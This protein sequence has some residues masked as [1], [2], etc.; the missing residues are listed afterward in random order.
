[1]VAISSPLAYS[2]TPG[3]LVNLTVTA[4]VL[5]IPAGGSV[6][7]SLDGGSEIPVAGSGNLYSL[8]FPGVANGNHDV[9]AIVRTD[10]GTEVASD[11]NS[12]VGTGGD[13][14]VTVGDSITNGV[15]DFNPANNDSADGRIVAIQSYQA[16]LSD[17]LTTTT[18]RP[19]IVFNEGIGGDKPADLQARIDSILERH[20]GANK[21]LLMIGTNGSQN[22][23]TRSG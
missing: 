18:G 16:R 14:Y 19:Q 9:A 21:V 3:N 20:P 5:N 11:T 7:F 10:E 22:T 1:M 6:G 23:N 8:V 12:M 15:G 13:Y 17:R 4:V 2:V